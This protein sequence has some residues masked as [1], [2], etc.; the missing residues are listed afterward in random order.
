MTRE[1]ILRR[2][3]ALQDYQ[4]SLWRI[5]EQSTE[6]DREE[7]RII[8]ALSKLYKFLNETH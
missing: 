4:M 6:A 3:I 7:L 5:N 2:I 1:Q 8:D